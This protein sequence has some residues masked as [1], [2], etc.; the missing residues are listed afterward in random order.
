MRTKALN[1]FAKKHGQ[2]PSKSAE[3]LNKDIDERERS[4]FLILIAALAAKANVPLTGTALADVTNRF[5]KRV[6]RQTAQNKIE[7]IKADADLYGW[8]KELLE[9]EKKR[10][11]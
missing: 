3:Q 5:G 1:D 10:T 8:D 9:A 2:T 11:Q 7:Q 6:S 4:T